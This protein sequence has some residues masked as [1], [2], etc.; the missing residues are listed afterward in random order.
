M[1]LA[2]T[3]VAAIHKPLCSF[4]S[5]SASMAW[6]PKYRTQLKMSLLGY[7][8]LQI[9]RFVWEGRRIHLR[10]QYILSKSLSL[11]QPF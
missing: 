2:T 4:Y 9:G 8:S 5:K 7:E 3:I 6:D 1:S 11:W 10:E